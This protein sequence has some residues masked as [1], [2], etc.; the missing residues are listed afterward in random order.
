VTCP[1]DRRALS[2]YREK[3]AR[4][5]K[6]LARR[7]PNSREFVVSQF[8]NPRTDAAI[9][10]R[11]ERA[12]QGG[13]GPCDFMTPTGAI[14]SRKL[15]RLEKAIHAYESAVK[16]ACASVRQCTYSGNALSRTINKRVYYSSDLNHFSVKGHARA[17]AAAWAAL[18]RR[19]VIPTG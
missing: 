14:V 15:V 3:L 9:Y 16:S 2:A 4:A 19:H 18:L 7:A 6:K 13:T 1:L 8:G 5:L 11:Q 17:A 10:T 12:A